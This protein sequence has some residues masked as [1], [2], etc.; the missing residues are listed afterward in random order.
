MGVRQPS[1]G[2][3]TNQT[4]CHRHRLIPT[5]QVAPFHLELFRP[6][7]YFQLGK[8]RDAF[9]SRQSLIP[10]DAH[11]RSAVRSVFHLA[12]ISLYDGCSIPSIDEMSVGHLVVVTLNI[13]L[14]G[15][16]QQSP[17]WRG[18]CN[19]NQPPPT[20]GMLRCRDA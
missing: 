15:T 14:E 6:S 10:R 3:Y 18:V 20:S 19:K 2:V 7:S 8:R 11:T 1:Q 5:R 17:K 12:E 4:I 9:L 16:Q 13:M